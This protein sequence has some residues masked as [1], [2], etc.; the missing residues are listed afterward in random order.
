MAGARGRTK[1]LNNDIG[2]SVYR[3]FSNAYLGGQ[4]VVS[5]PQP[6]YE[7]V[8][9]TDVVSLR[10]GRKAGNGSRRKSAYLHVN[11]FDLHR[12]RH[13]ALVINGQKIQGGAPV[14][15][16][17]NW[18]TPLYPPI[19]PYLSF[20]AL[21][22][23]QLIGYTTQLLARSNPS[24]P[25]V[26]IP[27]NIGEL[28]ELP[29]LLRSIGDQ[30]IHSYGSLVKSADRSAVGRLK[31]LFGANGRVTSREALNAIRRTATR[32]VANNTLNYKWGI[33][34]VWDDLKTLLDTERYVAKRIKQ[35]RDLK[36][37]HWFG[38]KVR[39]DKRSTTVT[40]SDLI[41]EST[42]A[43]VV[44]RRVSSITQDVWGTAR[45]RLPVTSVLPSYLQSDAAMR[46][47]A[48]QL[49]HGMTDFELLQTAWELFPW[50]WLYDWFGHFG[51]FLTAMNNNLQLIADNLCIM[52][53]TRNRE[54]WSI[55][56]A[57]DW[58]D[59]RP[60]PVEGIHEYKRRYVGMLAI[61]L[62]YFSVPILSA[63]KL[64]VL[65]SLAALKA[66]PR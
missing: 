15:S 42:E 33:A 56:S 19:D 39:L 26:S 21:S 50:S 9:C 38:T 20:P 30:V 6:S 61:P 65:S 12:V 40:S 4:F 22:P 24:A 55:I 2:T 10:Y 62:P 34:P 57:P 32:N 23:A 58:I 29:K 64:S 17:E 25:S 18:Q 37:K 8:Q 52:C 1:I 13:H 49:T 35:F 63:N 51:E 31:E 7:S 48:L 46:V 28:S 14:F 66:T 27:T 60:E 43:L 54:T 53:H 47:K 3:R 45:W 44:A 59:I 36:S 11:P 16:Y 41:V 5:N